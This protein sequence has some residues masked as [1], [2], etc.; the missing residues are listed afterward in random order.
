MWNN[1]I[2]NILLLNRVSFLCKRKVK[3]WKTLFS[4][5]SRLSASCLF[6]TKK[7]KILTSI[8]RNASQFKNSICTS[9]I[10]FNDTILVPTK[11]FPQNQISVTVPQRQPRNHNFSG[12]LIW[13]RRAS[14]KREARGNKK[15]SGV[16]AACRSAF[17]FYIFLPGGGSR[18]FYMP[19]SWRAEQK[20]R[21]TEGGRGTQV[22]RGRIEII[23][24]GTEPETGIPGTKLLHHSAWSGLRRH[25]SHDVYVAN[26]RAQFPER[27]PPRRP[28]PP[29]LPPR[30]SSSSSSSY[31][32]LRIHPDGCT[33]DVTAHL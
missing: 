24:E 22:R 33:P 19:L 28:F 15:C 32:H 18:Y 17:L 20:E 1:F 25:C 6:N 3:M 4:N 9:Y 23:G 27:C 2:N 14:Q 31:D 21:K 12:H 30:N 8:Y 26:I 7:I 29:L 11:R 10:R 13:E 5:I 16:R